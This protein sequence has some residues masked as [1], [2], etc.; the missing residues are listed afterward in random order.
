MLIAIAL[1]AGIGALG[2][3]FVAG[4]G[5][6]LPQAPGA[7]L[8]VPAPTE[9]VARRALDGMTLE[10]GEKD[11]GRYFAVSVDN[12]A[13]ARPLAGLSRAALVYEAPVEAGITRFLAVFLEGTDVPK[14]G[15]VRSARPYFLDWAA[16][17]NAILVHVG[18]SPAA[19][20][21]LE[22]GKL[23]DLDEYGS[24]KYF[25]REESR[26]APHNVYTSSDL[27]KKAADARGWEKADAVAA[28]KYKND[29]PEAER[30]EKATFT[31]GAAAPDH[32]VRWEYERAGNILRRS[33]GRNAQVDDGGRPVKAKNVAVMFTRVRVT[34]EVG[35][36]EVRTSGEGKAIVVVD[37]RAREGKWKK[38]SV[39]ER[40]RFFDS[41]G[42]EILFNA[43]TTWIAVVPDGTEF[44]AE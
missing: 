29:A 28:W 32:V 40:I 43:G 21:Q 38:A 34:D 4:Q 31:I 14:I 36:R 26:R 8:V 39:E 15:P 16:E 18:G 33:Q 10:E 41:D 17:M 5:A 2:W 20:D 9:D 37:G 7:L 44:N 13:Y 12:I 6:W 1:F 42:A 30:P 25:W 11:V 24:G 3:T 22:S 23:N 27:L 35:R 19:L